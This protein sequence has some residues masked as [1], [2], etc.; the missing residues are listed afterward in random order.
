MILNSQ[1]FKNKYAFHCK[2]QNYAIGIKFLIK[3]GWGVFIWRTPP[4]TRSGVEGQS[5]WSGSQGE[6]SLKLKAFLFPKSK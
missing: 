4:I 5:P 6:V 1:L 2:K 3:V